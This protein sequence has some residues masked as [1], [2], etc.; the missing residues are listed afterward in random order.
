MIIL[1]NHKYMYC[2]YVNTARALVYHLSDCSNIY[3]YNGH[4]WDQQT[5]LLCPLL[6]GY[7]TQ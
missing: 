1:S 7:L 4:H 6:R 5:C 3:M 2:M